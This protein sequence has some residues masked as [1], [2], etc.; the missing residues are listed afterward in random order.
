[1]PSAEK[2]MAS[3]FRNAD[4]VIGVDYLPKGLIIHGAYHDALLGQL[5]NEIITK[6]RGKLRQ[7]VFFHQDNTPVH[8]SVIVTA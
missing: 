5:R 1:M 2:V 8:T 6:R 4:G 3:L 7:G